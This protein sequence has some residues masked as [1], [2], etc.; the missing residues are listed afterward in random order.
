[1]KGKVVLNCDER[2]RSKSASFFI[3]GKLTYRY[4][5]GDAKAGRTSFS[6]SISE[7]EETL[8]VYEAQSVF[9][10]N[11]DIDAGK[12]EF[13]FNFQLPD[14]L[15]PSYDSPVISIVYSIGTSMKTSRL[16]K[17]NDMATIDILRPITE[18]LSEAIEKSNSDSPEKFLLIRMDSQ[19]YNIG[20]DILFSFCVDTDTKFNLLRA[21]VEHIEHFKKEK[22]RILLK[23]EIPSEEI[24]LHEWNMCFLRVNQRLPVSL[25]SH[26][27]QSILNLKVSIV[28]KLKS[29]I[30]ARIP[31]IAGHDLKPGWKEEREIAFGK[32]QF[33]TASPERIA[34]NWYNRAITHRDE[35]KIKEAIHSVETA[36][37]W[38]PDFAEALV[39]RDELKKIEEGAN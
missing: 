37:K 6:V 27:F 31:L 1:V 7:K 29:D 39:L 24:I 35:G 8:I 25:K 3:T 15:I 20:D 36:V 4:I 19:K 5:K 38:K 11:V 32:K 23:V 18:H 14:D 9:A 26:K 30:T 13:P 33:K 10:E 22:R 28:R 34:Q 2:F 16:E 17:L 21:E 12:H